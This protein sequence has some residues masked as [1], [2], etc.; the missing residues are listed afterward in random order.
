MTAGEW[1]PTATDLTEFDG[2]V[3]TGIPVARALTYFGEQNHQ[4]FS[5]QALSRSLLDF[6]MA[7]S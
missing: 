7:N 1:R 4:V 3:R 2:R 6:E 5:A